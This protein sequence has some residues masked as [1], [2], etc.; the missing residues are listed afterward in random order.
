LGKILS[1]V[2]FGSYVEGHVEVH[3]IKSHILAEGTP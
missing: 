1:K 3:K 2:V